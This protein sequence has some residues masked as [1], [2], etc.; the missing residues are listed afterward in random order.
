MVAAVEASAVTAEGVGDVWTIY[1]I[2]RGVS[3][4]ER[5]LHAAD[6]FSLQKSATRR[7]LKREQQTHED[8]EEEEG[9][10]TV[11]QASSLHIQTDL[12]RLLRSTTK[13]ET[14]GRLKRQ[15]KSLKLAQ[16]RELTGVSLPRHLRITPLEEDPL[17]FRRDTK[18][19]AQVWGAYLL[20]QL[21]SYSSSS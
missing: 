7:K 17:E 20:L 21:I 6:A 14:Q 16:V 9:V 13:L 5:V 19:V 18:G 2:E 1:Q 15:L 4:Y 12:E 10:L 8:E 3:P 11:P